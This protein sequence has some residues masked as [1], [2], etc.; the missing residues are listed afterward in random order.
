MELG[1]PRPGKDPGQAGAQDVEV[2]LSRM[3]V[4]LSQGPG[5]THIVSLVGPD[6]SKQGPGEEMISFLLERRNLRH[7]TE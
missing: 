4:T 5:L 6:S 7:G 1:S 2:F 3:A